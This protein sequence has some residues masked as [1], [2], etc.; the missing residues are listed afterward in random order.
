MDVCSKMGIECKEGV[1]GV[2]QLH[3]G[4]RLMW[5]WSVRSLEAVTARLF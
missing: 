5:C 1:R 2:S 3:S 4:Y